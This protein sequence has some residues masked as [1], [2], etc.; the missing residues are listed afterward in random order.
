VV[1]REVA[2]RQ[3]VLLRVVHERSILGEAIHQGGGQIIPAGLDLFLAL[4]GEHA[5]QG[6][7]DHALVGF[8]DAL[9]QVSGKVD[10]AAL[11]D[12]SLQLAADALGAAGLGVRDHQ[13]DVIEASLL[14]VGD[15]LRR[16]CRW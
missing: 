12:A 7:G 2:K 1:L 3:Y 14:E 4:L 6:S 11:P 16:G 13:L 5:A 15:E 8:G 10:T 9:Q